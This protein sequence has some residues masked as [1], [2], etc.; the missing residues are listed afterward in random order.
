[1]TAAVDDEFA[2]Q[3]TPSRF[4]WDSLDREA[5]QQLWAELVDWVGWFRVRYELATEVPGCWYRHGRMVEELTALM[6]AHRAAY[7]QANS[8][9]GD[10]QYW[11]GM[12]GWH[13][14]YLRP[15]LAHLGD[16]GVQGCDQQ[17]CTAQVRDVHTFHDIV[18]WID[19]DV[20]ARPPRADT[21]APRATI[22]PARMAQLVKDGDAEPVDIT[23]PEG[24]Y[25][26]D[27]ALW[28]LDPRRKVFGAQS[29]TPPDASSQ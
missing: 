23:D 19:A 5:A 27:G 16:L 12:A 2:P 26:Y 15:F 25:R 20:D 8:A 13:S 21:P 1:M 11:P 14:Q 6:A 3:F 29:D 10:V 28:E 4:C 22:T 17:N 24:G 18:T 7:D 9:D